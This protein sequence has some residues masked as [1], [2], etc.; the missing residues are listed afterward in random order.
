MKFSEITTVLE[1]WGLRVSEDQIQR[2]TGDIVQAV[3]LLF[4]LQITGITP[5]QLQQP[6]HRSLSVVGEFPVSS[7]RLYHCSAH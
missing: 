5:E 1:T 3:Y 4:L 6:M 2:P 7:T